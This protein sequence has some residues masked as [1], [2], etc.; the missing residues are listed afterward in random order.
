MAQVYKIRMA[1]G[2][3]ITP[4][5]WTSTPYWSTVEI[6][7]GPLSPLQAFSYGLGGDVPGS[8]GPRKSTAVDTNMDGQ[9]GVLAENEQLLINS[10]HISFFTIDGE[11]PTAAADTTLDNVLRL[12]AAVQGVLHISSKRTEFSRMGL[13]FY[14]ASMG[15]TNVSGPDAPVASAA[16]NGS[17]SVEGRRMF[18][19][20]HS[21]AGGETFDFTLEFP[22]GSVPNLTLAGGANSR[23]RARVYFDGFRRRPVA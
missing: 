12:Q 10:I 13:G 17:S 20:P 5:D 4:A 9:G 2:V 8:P 11:D 19:T 22:L 15:V 21:V 1:D 6:G 16:T 23:I 3:T 7:A 18:A 14:A